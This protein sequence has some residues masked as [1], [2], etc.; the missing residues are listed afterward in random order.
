MSRMK[1]HIWFFVCYCYFS[2]RTLHFLLG[3]GCS[4][5]FF[6]LRWKYLQDTHFHACYLRISFCI[7]F[8]IQSPYYCI[9][10]ML[11]HHLRHRNQSSCSLWTNKYQPEVATEVL[12]S[13]LLN[14]ICQHVMGITVLKLCR[15]SKTS[16]F[17]EI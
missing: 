8:I 15:F 5:L 13:F 4:K 7:I 11:S 17:N 9:C 10:R 16:F 2:V 6:S 12:P 1:S 14:F 3:T